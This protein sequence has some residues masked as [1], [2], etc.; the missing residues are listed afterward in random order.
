M[1]RVARVKVQV[2][3]IRNMYIIH[4]LLEFLICIQYY[5][6]SRKL[7]SRASPLGLD[8]EIKLY[9]ILVYLL[10]FYCILKQ[11]VVSNPSCYSRELRKVKN[12]TSYIREIR[13]HM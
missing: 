10:G 7:F 1:R 6:A 9:I 13:N 11:F 12:W 5:Y 3:Q 8:R 2:F 4:G